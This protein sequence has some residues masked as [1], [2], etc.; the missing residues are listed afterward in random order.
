MRYCVHTGAGCWYDAENER[1][2]EGEPTRT[3]VINQAYVAAI[4]PTVRD[5]L[6]RAGI[7]LGGLLNQALGTEQ[8]EALHLKR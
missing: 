4:A 8:R 6:V 7:R 3:V 2:D 5:R 1:L